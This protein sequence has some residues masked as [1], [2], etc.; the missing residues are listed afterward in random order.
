M[1]SG[2][3]RIRGR[4]RHFSTESKPGGALI[5][6]LVEGEDTRAFLDNQLSTQSLMETRGLSRNSFDYFP[7]KARKA[8]LSIE[9]RA[10]LMID[11]EKAKNIT[12]GIT[13]EEADNLFGAIHHP[14]CPIPDNNRF[15]SAIVSVNRGFI[16]SEVFKMRKRLDVETLIHHAMVGMNEAMDTYQ[17]SPL[18]SLT[19]RGIEAPDL[20]K[21]LKKLKLIS[22]DETVSKI[23]TT[24]GNENIL[25]VAIQNGKKQGKELVFRVVE[26]PGKQSLEIYGNGK[27]QGSS[28]DKAQ[29]GV[30]GL[31]LLWTL[32]A[33]P[34]IKDPEILNI[35]YNAGFNSHAV[36]LMRKHIRDAIN[37]ED[38]RRTVLKLHQIQQGHQIH[39]KAASLDDGAGLPT[40][41]KIA[42]ALGVFPGLVESHLLMGKGGPMQLDATLDHD[43][44]TTH[45]ESTED[46]TI[47]R[48]DEQLMSEDGKKKLLATLSILPVKDRTMYKLTNGIGVDRRYYLTEIGELFYDMTDQAV[49]LINQHSTRTVKA[50][51]ARAKGDPES[52]HYDPRDTAMTNIDV[53]YLMKHGRDEKFRLFEETDHIPKDALTISDKEWDER[54][55]KALATM[56]AEMQDAFIDYCFLR[57][58]SG[59]EYNDI[60]KEMVQVAGGVDKVARDKTREILG[61]RLKQA[62]KWL[63]NPLRKRIL[64]GRADSMTIT[65]ENIDLIPYEE[66]VDMIKP[67]PNNYKWFA[68]L[69]FQT[70]LRGRGKPLSK[71]EIASKMGYDNTSVVN[72]VQDRLYAHFNRAVSGEVSLEQKYDKSQFPD[73][74]GLN[75]LMKKSRV[76]PM[77][78]TEA[79]PQG[80]NQVTMEVDSSRIPRGSIL[81]EFTDAQGNVTLPN[82]F[83]P[84]TV[85]RTKL[86]SVLSGLSPEEAHFANLVIGLFP[87]GIKDGE[88]FQALA[89]R[90][91]LSKGDAETHE[92]ELTS[93]INGQL[94]GAGPQEFQ[95][96]IQLEKKK[97]G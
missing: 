30:E 59:V 75:R 60:R 92:R 16:A 43:S 89:I 74:D 81:D 7:G 94:N 88:I 54:L 21:S 40:V 53:E 25:V 13:Q 79:T 31:T 47:P 84:Q 8:A 36:S 1:T 3:T 66:L 49:S 57:H 9:K 95:P 93:Y 23:E 91:R 97:V 80:N 12:L 42:N 18:F 90:F 5:H 50:F 73:K 56:P 29:G 51:A 41:D 55:G 65:P 39:R 77:A 14:H 72:E 38:P 44:D 26:E 45:L 67:L 4:Q 32:K 35:Y 34:D 68:Q 15:R 63:Q 70:Q 17:S 24:K 52:I 71:E 22:G 33:K 82:R 2:P 27:K 76:T 83:K 87:I 19:S 62:R 58:F 61:N 85:K 37:E 69:L 78:N 6:P 48:P 11:P 46:V 96:S 20:G 86:D 10:R 28:K 64:D